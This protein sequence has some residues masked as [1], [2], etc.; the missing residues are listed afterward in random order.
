ML[1]NFLS[2]Q[3]KAATR[4]PIWQKKLA[5]NIL[6]GFFLFIF[7]VY[8]ILLGILIKQ[9][10]NEMFPHK[11]H[12]RLFNGILLY[13]FFADLVLRFMMQSLPTLTIES[14]LHLPVKKGFIIRYMI[15]RTIPDVFNFLPLCIFIP[16][17]F[18][19]VLPVG[20]TTGSII[21]ISTL[22][23]MILSNNFLAVY[24]KRL[25]GVRPILTVCFW[26]V[27]IL[28][29]LGDRLRLISLSTFSSN[30][31]N[32]IILHSWSIVMPTCLLILT[33]K[34]QYQFLSRHL[35]PDE[36][37]KRKVKEV[38]T[39]V[40]S[41][42]LKSMGLTGTIMALEFKL[43]LR[44]NRAKIRLYMAPIILLY[45]LII[46]PDAINHHQD[47][48]L[49]FAG[50]ILTGGMMLNYCIYS[51]GFE[52]N[53]FDGLLTKNID[54]NQYI[55]VKYYIAVLISTIFYIVSCS[56]VY[57]GFKILL[58]NTAMYFYNIGILAFILLYFATFNKK[59][60]ELSR[61]G[62]MN[63][64]GM[65]AANWLATIPAFI[66][67]FLIYALFRLLCYPDWGIACTG[68]LGFIGIFFNKFFL[69]LITNGFYKRKYVMA[70]YFRER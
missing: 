58:I 3:V 49:M 57:Y 68:V 41:R 7:A 6:I 1:L 21:W 63:Y 13:Y 66:L 51:F 69:R 44:N 50:V 14:F 52:S 46:Y 29:I 15:W 43:Y 18:T 40:K 19:I 64:Q 9:I 31:F 23:L 59:R 48:L 60:I 10:L 4:S 62:M 27:F 36:I 32:S 33:Y 56:Y 30:I 22:L 47:G 53:Y 54:F 39:Q 38:K 20:G 42:F 55:R 61:G 26:L 45:G 2:L 24:L 35:Y 67:P 16:A 11:D 17:I 65:G 37:Q 34:L 25:L 70:H 8:L 12:L 5:L 28:L